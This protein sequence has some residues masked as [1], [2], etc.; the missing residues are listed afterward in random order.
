MTL[1]FK[2]PAPW[3]SVSLPGG[4]RIESGKRAEVLISVDSLK[5]DVPINEDEFMLIASPAN[6]E[7]GITREIKVTVEV[8]PIPQVTI[9]PFT[10]FA[11][12]ALD[13]SELIVDAEYPII[14]TAARF[15]PPCFVLVGDAPRE[16]GV[17]Q[18]TLPVRL[19]L[20]QNRKLVSQSVSFELD[21][22]G[23][24]KALA[25]QFDLLVKKPATLVIE[26]LE[27]IELLPGT[28]EELFLTLSNAGQEVLSVETIEI[29][30]LDEHQDSVVP[31]LRSKRL[32]IEP[33][34][35]ER[36]RLGAAADPQAKSGEYY[37]AIQFQ[38][39]DPDP[40]HNKRL[41]TVKV[42]D[43]EYPYF[44]SLDFGTTN[45]AVACFLEGTKTPKNLFLEKRTTDPKIY[46]NIFFKGYSD[47][48]NPRFAVCI[49]KE[50]KM[51]GAM[52]ENRSALRRFIKAIKTRA[53]KNHTEEIRFTEGG[54]EGR[55]KL[56]AEEIIK[57]ILAEL[58]KLTQGALKKKPAKFI[59]SVPTRFTLRRKEILREA[60]IK[61]AES[62][63][64][65]INKPKIIDESLAAGLFYILV[66]G[67]RDDVLKKKESYT[68]MILDFGG[69]TT[70]ITVFRVRQRLKPDGSVEDIDRIEII[71]AWGD[72]TLGGEE[73]TRDIA[74]ILLERFLGKSIKREEQSLEIS[75]LEDEAEAVKLVVS[76]L[77]RLK[78][79]DGELDIESAIR[80]A[81]PILRENVAYISEPR[82]R[83]ISDD[84]LRIYLENYLKNDR[85]LAVRSNDF[86]AKSFE[87]QSV[88]IG[89]KEVIEIYERRLNEL[90]SEL[91]L[92][93]ERI[94]RKEG[95][96]EPLKK[97]DVFL[98]A[99]QS[100]QFPTVERVLKD[101]AQNENVDYVKDPEGKLALKECV[102]LGALHYSLYLDQQ[103]GP[104]ITGDKKIWTRLGRLVPR[105][106]TG[107]EFE[108]LV[109]WG[110]PYS[111]K[112]D[113]FLLGQGSI[114]ETRQVL[115]L[116]VRENLRFSNDP[117]NTEVYGT[118]ELPLTEDPLEQ[119][120]CELRIDEDGK[121]KPFCRIGRRWR[122]MTP[123]Q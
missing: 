87:I 105:F 103:S 32:A 91:Y 84:E 77:P 56:E 15:D 36:V 122:E 47:D 119:Y 38:S 98:L 48:K 9:R 29:A 33:E 71:G 99:G 24:D 23:L 18:Q 107:T 95:L 68:L 90:K 108:E 4:P 85:Q 73:I 6:S 64:L 65:S 34:K 60:F 110:A 46:S 93:L 112:A 41:L 45:S 102:S 20:P 78:Q 35:R 12:R 75:R 16:M 63:P 101:L 118:F 30:P 37:F 114:N 17:D 121:I 81:S 55:F 7:K 76:E 5:L 83:S 115:E 13:S 67:P 27:D 74:Q 92:L 50:A 70:D 116:E 54:P 44:V 113:T 117:D 39:S 123:K 109:E 94:G 53:G 10:V 96:A 80:E 1:T 59:L 120:S 26:G 66:R 79:S 42:T 69:G 82:T 97:V 88:L 3:L 8:S 72:A 31:T 89:E 21:V 28:E 22:E 62:I 40:G 52:P 58:L 2:R 43:K 25:G 14:V 111:S 11:G 49:G 57:F 106:G 51:L 19:A 86:D 61:A 104:K 100:S